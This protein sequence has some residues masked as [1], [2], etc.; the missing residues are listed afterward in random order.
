MSARPA[1][2]PFARAPDCGAVTEGGEHTRWSAVRG[3]SI[4]AAVTRTRGS[5]PVA[6]QITSEAAALGVEAPR[7]G[8]DRGQGQ[9]T[10]SRE[11]AVRG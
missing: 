3:R 2:A 9:V 7:W 4:S 11:Q 10:S 5:K 1:S 6:D 8:R